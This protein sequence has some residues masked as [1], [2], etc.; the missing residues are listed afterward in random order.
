MKSRR[1]SERREPGSRPA[2][3]P[4]AGKP[5]HEV[6]SSPQLRRRRKSAIAAVK[7]DTML[8]LAAEGPRVRWAA[9]KPKEKKR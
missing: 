7:K 2:R 6:A 3:S 9:G 4:K 5:P 8:S 1:K